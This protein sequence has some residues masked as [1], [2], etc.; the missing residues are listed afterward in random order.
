MRQW[1]ITAAADGTASEP[2][3]FLTRVAARTVAPPEPHRRRLA[4]CAATH[5]AGLGAATCSRREGEEGKSGVE[6][7]LARRR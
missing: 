4:E 5:R 6:A 2:F 1:R 3:F 7:L